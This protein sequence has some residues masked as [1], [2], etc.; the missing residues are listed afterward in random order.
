MNY[1]QGFETFK[2]A[3]RYMFQ[4]SL[5]DVLIVFL[6][7]FASILVLILLPYFISRYIKSNMVKREFKV[8]GESFG[9]EEEEINVLYE[10]AR[11]LSEPSKLFH[12]KYV[13]EKCAGKLVKKNSENI[14]IIVS[15]RKKLKFE[16]LPWFL[17]LSTTRD[18][19]LYQ[20][21]FISYKGKSYSAAVWEKTEKELHI[22]ILDRLEDIPKVGEKIRFSFLR[23]DDG[24]YYFQEE[25]LSSYLDGNKVVLV[26]PHTEKLGKIQLRE[27]V[28]WK[29]SI[30]ARVFFFGRVVTPEEL[31]LM[32]EIPKEAFVEGTIEDIST[33]GLRVCL[34]NL[35]EPKEGESLLIEFEWKNNYFGPILSEIRNVRI[36]TEKIC[37][38]VKFLNLKN[39]QEET[40]RKLILEE[41]REVLRTYKMGK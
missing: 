29:V 7:L 12:S 23:E 2:E 26:L 41:Q 16:H 8:V 40:I 36:S 28:R 5:Q 24:R 38:G 15:V 37:I 34:K 20:T 33:G 3:T 27:S 6:G 19:E 22:A 10:C 25:I 21:G 4:P 18:I 1:Q 31:L 9:L 39:L 17:P 35:V 14:P 30:P 11:N 13:F 32:E